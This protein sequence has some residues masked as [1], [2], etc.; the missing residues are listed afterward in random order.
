M[1][2][3]DESALNDKSEI[4]EFIELDLY[5]RYYVFYAGGPFAA[6]IIFSLTPS[7]MFSLLHLFFGMAVVYCLARFYVHGAVPIFLKNAKDYLALSD[8]QES[9]RKNKYEKKRW[10]GYEKPA[11][12]KNSLG[13]E[14]FK[15]SKDFQTGLMDYILFFFIIETAVVV[16]P[17][18]LSNKYHLID[19]G[20]GRAMMV[21][22]STWM[23]HMSFFF[24]QRYLIWQKR[25]KPKLEKLKQ[26][27]QPRA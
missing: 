11:K 8:M 7:V 10:Y 21:G 2:N 22:I 23:F 18:Y 27:A 3:H 15:H 14:M 4:V 5:Y 19:I 16:F 20:F 25:Y 6:I 1:S 17:I 9:L 12:L 13:Y 24:N 26:T